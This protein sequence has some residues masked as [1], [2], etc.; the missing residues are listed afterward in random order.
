MSRRL[1][2]QPGESRTPSP[3]HQGLAGWDGEAL[4]ETSCPTSHLSLEAPRDT[5]L[6][7]AWLGLPMGCLGMR[8]P[9]LP[10]A[11]NTSKASGHRVSSAH[12]VPTATSI[13]H[14]YPPDSLRAAGDK[15]RDGKSPQGQWS[16]RRSRAAA[17][18]CCP[19]LHI[20]GD[21]GSQDLPWALQPSPGSKGAEQWPG[22][23]CTGQDPAHQPGNR[24]AGASSLGLWSVILRCW[25][26]STLIMR[27]KT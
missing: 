16:Q 3:C 8:K 13:P 25:T 14:Q 7:P 24:V 11:Q 15:P 5:A 9:L 19:E 2:A 12:L 10:P 17:G 22:T 4:G 18:L 1:K 21:S 6:P 20:P 27:Q 26:P 23:P